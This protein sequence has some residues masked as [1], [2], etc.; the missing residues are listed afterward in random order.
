MK[1]MLKRADGSTSQ[2]GLWDNIRAKAAA[3]KKAGKKGKAPSEDILK[4]ERA[5]NA[6]KNGGPRSARVEARAEKVM[7]KAKANWKEAEA[8]RKFDKTEEKSN[9]AQDKFGR[10]ASDKANQLYAKAGRQE[11]RAKKL[12]ERSEF[13]KAAGKKTG[14]KS[15]S[16]FLEESKELT[17]GGPSKRRYLVGGPE[18]PTPM[19]P[20]KQA[21]RDAYAKELGMVK[22]ATGKFVNPPK[23][24]APAPAS[25]MDNMA[26]GLQQMFTKPKASTKSEVAGIRRKT[27][28]KKKMGGKNC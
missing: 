19:T 12:K 28:G 21:A 15:M 2:R 9:F 22:D 5:I 10:N 20:E 3:N 7:G 4:Q 11:G 1:K 18:K 27:G 26:S 6:K 24:A 25:T 16:S 13:L 8:I 14:G 23:K 17:F